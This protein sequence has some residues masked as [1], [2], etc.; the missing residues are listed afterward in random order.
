MSLYLGYFFSSSY[1]ASVKIEIN[2]T[3][4]VTTN[5]YI[6]IMSAVKIMH[7]RTIA[8]INMINKLLRII[9][10]L[11]VNLFIINNIKRAVTPSD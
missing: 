8:I 1:L 6:N 3:G 5:M 4:A 9:I 2:A 10:S 7:I 11:V